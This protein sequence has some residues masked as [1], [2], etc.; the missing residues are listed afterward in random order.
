MNS[1]YDDL[2]FDEF[3]RIEAVVTMRIDGHP[4]VKTMDLL[5]VARLQD[6]F[7]RGIALTPPTRREQV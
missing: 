4:L 2:Q 6:Y 5:L 1:T 3:G 7:A